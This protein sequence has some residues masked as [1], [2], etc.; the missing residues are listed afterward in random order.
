MPVARYSTR[1]AAIVRLE[2]SSKS[3]RHVVA[4]PHVRGTMIPEFSAKIHHMRIR[5]TEFNLLCL[6]RKNLIERHKLWLKMHN[7]LF[8]SLV[9][10][11]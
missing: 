6:S 5:D 11:Q 2:F 10:Q 1:Y 4:T 9:E 8:N 3:R 7:F